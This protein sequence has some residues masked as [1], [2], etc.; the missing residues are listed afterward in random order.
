MKFFVTVI[1]VNI[2]T[3]TPIDNVKA[4]P[5]TTLVPKKYRITQAKTV[6]IFESKILVNALSKPELIAVNK[7][8]PALN[9]SFVLSKI[10]MLASTAIPTDRMKPAIP[11]RVN[12]TGTILKIEN[13]INA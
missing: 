5:L 12:V 6:V 3:I 10:K 13:N 11:A 9:S 2:E 7:F 1:A 4:K 8:R